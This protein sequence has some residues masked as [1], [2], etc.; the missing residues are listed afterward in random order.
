MP[1]DQFDL[2]LSHLL[3]ISGKL[4]SFLFH[5]FFRIQ[6]THNYAAVD[7]VCRKHLRAALSFLL[8]KAFKLNFLDGNLCR[9]ADDFIQATNHL[10]VDLFSP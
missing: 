6:A 9:E 7:P 10:R 2:T 4:K 8:F 3:N 5:F 1:Q